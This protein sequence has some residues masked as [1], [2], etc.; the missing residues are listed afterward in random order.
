LQ[1]VEQEAQI[2]MLLHLRQVEQAVEE[3]VRLEQTV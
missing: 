2:Q 1:V 3:R